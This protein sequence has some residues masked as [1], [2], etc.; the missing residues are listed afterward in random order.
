METVPTQLIGGLA[1]GKAG[2][3]NEFAFAKAFMRVRG[4][5]SGEHRCHVVR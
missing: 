3:D 4:V 1:G 2:C 5:S